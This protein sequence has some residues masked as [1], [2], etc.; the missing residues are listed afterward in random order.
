MPD[1]AP[2]HPAQIRETLSPE[3]EPLV[4]HHKAPL[5]A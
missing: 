1:P 5:D 4:P 2:Q 3:S